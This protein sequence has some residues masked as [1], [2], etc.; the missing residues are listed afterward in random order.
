MGFTKSM[1]VNF[2]TINYRPRIT[3]F[4]A[5]S[6]NLIFRYSDDTF[7][8][9]VYLEYKEPV[10]V[11]KV[12]QNIAA[13]SNK[14]FEDLTGIISNG[15][16][17]T[18][19]LNDLQDD[20][21][22]NTKVKK[23]LGCGSVAVA[24][25]TEDGK[26]LKLTNGNHFFLNRPVEDFDAP[27]YKKGRSRGGRTYY[28]IEEKCN[29]HG[30]THEFV[31]MIIERIREKG[32]RVYDLDDFDVHQIGMSKEGKLYLV[33]HECAQYKTI[34]HKL[35]DVVKKSNFPEQVRKLLHY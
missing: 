27:I 14:K 16:L 35:F 19:F 18:R 2:S 17:M 25:E 7:D 1:K 12:L 22:L 20:E 24:F 28:Y 30:L 6:D 11:K 13:K 8:N 32:Y 15:K 23:M 26:V 21:V 29:H 9:S 33:D 3:P 5:K 34:F 31:E 10:E 4:T